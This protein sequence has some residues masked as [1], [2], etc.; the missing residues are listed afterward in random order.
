[1]KS[2]HKAIHNENKCCLRAWLSILRVTHTYKQSKKKLKQKKKRFSVF[3]LLDRVYALFSLNIV[4]Y[5]IIEGWRIRERG[6]ERERVCVCEGKCLTLATK[7]HEMFGE[8]R[9]EKR[10]KI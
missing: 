2:Y 3:S 5:E 6:R 7:L 4:R 8:K 9:T 10:E 1:M